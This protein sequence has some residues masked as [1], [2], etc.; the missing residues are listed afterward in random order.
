MGILDLTKGENTEIKLTFRVLV[1]FVVILIVAYGAMFLTFQT[2]AE[3]SH[4]NDKINLKIDGL[5]KEVRV[6]SAYQAITF[7]QQKV[8][9]MERDGANP[10]DIKA[11]K[12]RLGIAGSYRDCL[13]DEKPNCELI[14]QQMK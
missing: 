1:G 11:E 7:Y 10:V 6:G 2:K 12:K 8:D 3:A 9:R 4:Q 5:T 13:V 14:R